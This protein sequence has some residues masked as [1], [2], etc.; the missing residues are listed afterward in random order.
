MKTNPFDLVYPVSESDSHV[1]GL[2]KLEYFA[3]T[4]PKDELGLQFAQIINPD[5]YPKDP[6]SAAIWW[7][8]THAK[9]AI[10]RAKILINQLNKDNEITQSLQQRP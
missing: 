5:R 7:E 10:I 3:A 1:G 8:N 4:M 9:W 2:T 6:L